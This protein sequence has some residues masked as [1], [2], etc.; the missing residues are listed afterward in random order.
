MVRLGVPLHAL[1]GPAISAALALLA[2][3]LTLSPLLSTS[4]WSA[5]HGS[6]CP[7][8]FRVLA[9]TRAASY[10]SAQSVAFRP[11]SARSSCRSSPTRAT[12][13]PIRS[14]C[15]VWLAECLSDRSGGSW[16]RS[17]RTHSARITSPN[18]IHDQPECDTMGYANSAGRHHE[19]LIDHPTQPDGRQKLQDEIA[20]HGQRDREERCK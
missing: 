7:P 17:G 1:H 11:V 8:R 20:S 14:T 18:I 16:T 9:V 2:Q 19:D 5:L 6:T 3:V 10:S 12:P 13:P 4:C 15:V